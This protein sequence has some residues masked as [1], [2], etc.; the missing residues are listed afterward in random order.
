VNPSIRAFRFV[1]IGWSIAAMPALASAQPAPETV[2]AWDQ[3]VAIAEARID[4]ERELAP[5]SR[6]ISGETTAIEGGTIHHWRGTVFIPGTT[7]DRLVD[8]LLNPRR[9]AAQQE[10]VA[11]SRTIARNGNTVK[12]YIRLVR[13]AIVTVEYDTEHEMTF[14]RWSP[15]LTTARSVATSIREVGGNDHGFLWRIVSNWKYRQTSGGV[16]VELES[17]TLS[18]SIPAVVRPVAMPIIRHVA[19]ESMA[20]TLDAFGRRF[21]D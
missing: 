11:E 18:R 10:D 7:V 3:Y 5:S 21:R 19:R 6:D 4:R 9:D 1:A 13:R 15:S 8:E 16:I 2:Q 20:R 12:T 14:R 17:M